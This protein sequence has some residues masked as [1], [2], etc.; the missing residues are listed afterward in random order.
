MRTSFTIFLT[1]FLFNNSCSDQHIH[2]LKTDVCI[3]GAGSAGI[4][5]ALAASRSGANVILVEKEKMVGGT[6]VQSYVNTWEPGPGCSYSYEIYHRLP[7][8]ARGVA[9]QVHSYD[10]D[11]PYGLSLISPQASYNHSLRR[12]DLDVKTETANVVFDVIEFD[13]TVRQMLKETG[14]CKLLLNTKFVNA[15]VIHKKIKTIEAISTSGQKYQVSAKV[16]IDCTGGSFVCRNAGCEIMLGEEPR[17][18]FG[19]PSAPEKPEISLNA[20]SLCYQI[21]PSKN[22]GISDSLNQSELDDH[23]VAHVTGPVGPDQKLTVNPLGIIDGKCILEKPLDELYENGKNLVDKHWAKLHTYPHF[24]D[25]EFDSYAPKLGIRESY[26]VVCQYV[27]TQN[28]LLDGLT[29]QKHEDIITLADH[30]MDIHGGNSSLK[31]LH[32]AYGV[33]YRCLIPKGLDNLLVAGR[34]A[35]FSHIA[36]SSCR[37]SRTMMSLGHAAGFAAWLCASEEIAVW[38]VPVNRV[39]DEMNLKLRPKED[40]NADPLPVAVKVS[41]K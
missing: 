10:K 23:V 22:P 41:N 8:D 37:L 38:D 15:R 16:F 27:L 25:Y 21:K 33:P 11:E 29:K 13:H 40:L 17:S 1:L 5:A 31:I 6:S 3:I 20:I 19:E 12:S 18:K 32:E 9:K 36:A 35:G 14:R 7:P 34:G 2:Q 39:Q 28:D 26:R 4:G 24:K 30:P